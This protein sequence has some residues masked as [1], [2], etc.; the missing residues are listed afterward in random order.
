[1][2]T[3]TKMEL[4]NRDTKGEWLRELGNS[5]PPFLYDIVSYITF[6]LNTRPNKTTDIVITSRLIDD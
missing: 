3:L 1:M 6:V 5:T 2:K 4:E